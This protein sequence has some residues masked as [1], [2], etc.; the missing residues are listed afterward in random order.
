L[1]WEVVSVADFPEAPE[2]Q[3]NGTTFEQNAIKKAATI[4]SVLGM[5]AL[6]DDSGLEVDALEGRPGVYSARYAGEQATDEENWRKLLAELHDVPMAK[7]TARFRC[8]LALIE[9]GKEPIVA[10]GA[11]EGI[12]LREPAGTNGFGYDPVFFLPQRLCTMAQLDKQEKNKLSHRAVAM[13][14]LMEKIREV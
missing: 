6:A 14:N 2:V 13:N 1:G 3:E 4:A 12:I 8:V 5:T 9:P 11:C 7:R 10:S